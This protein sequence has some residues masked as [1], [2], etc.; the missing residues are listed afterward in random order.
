VL[1]TLFEPSVVVG[2]QSGEECQLLSTKAL[3]APT[4]ARY[5]ANVLRR[6]RFAPR[7]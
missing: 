6:H 7:P 5:E 3:N 4:V 1:A 2:A